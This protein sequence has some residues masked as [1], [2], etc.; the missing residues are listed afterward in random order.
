MLGTGDEKNKK[1]Q[2]LFPEEAHKLP[3]KNIPL[4]KPDILGSE[5][6]KQKMM[7]NHKGCTCT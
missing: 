1:K 3:E 2:N 6:G 5:E 4:Q 7:Q